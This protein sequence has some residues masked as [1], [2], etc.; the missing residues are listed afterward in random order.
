MPTTA[1]RAT[2]DAYDGSPA[3]SWCSLE[4]MAVATGSRQRR[5]PVDPPQRDPEAPSAAAGA[6]RPPPLRHRERSSPVKNRMLEIGTSGSVRGGDGNIP[7]YSALGLAQRREIGREG[8]RIGETRRCRRRSCRRPAWCAAT[9][10]LQEQ[11][12]EQAREHPHRQE[13]AGPARDPA[14]AV[15][16]Y[17]A[18]RHDHV[19]VRMVGQRRAPGVQHRG[20]AD[21]GAEMLRDRRRW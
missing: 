7:T 5:V 14:R 12:P 3:R 13:E 10:R 17:A 4:E 18:A 19:D 2:L 16:R 8:L 15:E 6:D 1:Y 9:Q 20:D 21:A 11:P